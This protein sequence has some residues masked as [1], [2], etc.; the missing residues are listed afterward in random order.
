MNINKKLN[1][2]CKT[3]KR[4]VKDNLGTVLTAVGIVGWTAAAVCTGK[5]TYEAT[6]RINEREVAENKD[7]L[8]KKE[9]VETVWPCYIPAASMALVSSACLIGADR[10]HAKR[11]TALAAAYGITEKAFA[12]YKAKALETLGPTK[13][14]NIRNAVAKDLVEKNPVTETEVIETGH[15]K[16]L[17]YDPLINRYF[18]SDVEYIRRCVN[19][20]NERLLHEDYAN[21]NDF[22]YLM[23]LPEGAIGYN[24][25]WDVNKGLISMNFSSCLASNNDPCLSMD[26]SVNPI[27]Y[28][29]AI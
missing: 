9:I 27:W 23:G 21:L 8:S 29:S 28:G 19:D 11:N 15:G 14:K 25:G 7:K 20:I 12:E 4:F 1:K 6:L 26:Y 22:Y 17:C 13:E 2:L 24:L 10:A 16:T 18:R 3:G 5:A